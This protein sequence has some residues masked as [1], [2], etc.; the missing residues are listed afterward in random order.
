[1][2]ERLEHLEAQMKNIRFAD[3]RSKASEWLR[4]RKVL[5]IGLILATVIA[6]PRSSP[7]QFLPSPCC[8]ILSVGLGSVTGAINNVVGSGLNALRSTMN[9]IEAFERTVVA[10]GS[11]YEPGQLLDLFGKLPVIGTI[12]SVSVARRFRAKATRTNIAFAN[13][14]Q[15]PTSS[16]TRRFT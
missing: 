6:V 4:S 5:V 12:R 1:L 7:A 3:T 10:K 14:D 8:A 15:I 13:T 2:A 9:S 16:V 11:D